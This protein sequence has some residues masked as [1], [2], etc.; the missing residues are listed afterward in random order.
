[1]VLILFTVGCFLIKIKD[2]KKFLFFS[3]FELDSTSQI[4]NILRILY[5]N[6][7]LVKY[8]PSLMRLY[9]CRNL[10]FCHEYW[11][12]KII[13]KLCILENKLM[14]LINYILWLNTFWIYIYI[15]LGNIAK[16]TLINDTMEKKLIFIIL[17]HDW[18]F[19]KISS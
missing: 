18:Y 15:T 2:Y 10:L 1:M 19:Y 13:H 17:I 5:F 9:F 11:T 12:V 4:G 8:L 6:N 7:H 3:R 14:M 16:K